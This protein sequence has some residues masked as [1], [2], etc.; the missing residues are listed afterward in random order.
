[1]VV[2][3]LAEVVLSE[4]GVRFTVKP[5]TGQNFKFQGKIENEQAIFT[6]PLLY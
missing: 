4:D 2:L 3:Q 6:L 1:M 5:S